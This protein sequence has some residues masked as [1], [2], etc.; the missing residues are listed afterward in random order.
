MCTCVDIYIILVGIVCV[1]VLI[2]IYN[3]SRYSVCTCVD[4]YI[5][6]VDIVCVL[7]LIYIYIILVGIVCVLSVSLHTVYIK[8]H[9]WRILVGS[10]R[11]NVLVIACRSIYDRCYLFYHTQRQQRQRPYTYN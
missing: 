8:L 1:L 9:V 6:L 4:I 10:S 7:V 2:Y 5:I 11:R 3:T